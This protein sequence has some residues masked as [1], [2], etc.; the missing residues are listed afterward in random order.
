MENAVGELTTDG[1]SRALLI[2]FEERYDENF[3]D[4]DNLENKIKSLAIGWGC[5]RFWTARSARTF[6]LSLLPQDMG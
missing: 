1:A 5:F 6:R 4:N 2:C 3:P